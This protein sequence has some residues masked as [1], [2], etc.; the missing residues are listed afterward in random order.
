MHSITGP[1]SNHVLSSW[2]LDDFSFLG[3]SMEDPTPPIDTLE[4]FWGLK[5]WPGGNPLL[6][7]QSTRQQK[8]VLVFE[9]HRTQGLHPM[10]K[11]G[12]MAFLLVSQE[13]TSM[14][15]LPLGGLWMAVKSIRISAPRCWVSA[16]RYIRLQRTCLFS[17]NPFFRGNLSP[18]EKYV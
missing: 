2:A 11:P 1:K 12:L 17:P 16:F 15:R 5:T 7:A 9:L 6:G 4:G 3:L 10:G 13:K 18:P 8:S 14:L